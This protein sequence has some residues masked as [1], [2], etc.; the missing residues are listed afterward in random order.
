MLESHRVLSSCYL[1]VKRVISGREAS[2][3]WLGN[4]V[5][6]KA[7]G[8]TRN[9]DSS[10]ARPVS[11]V[12]AQEPSGGEPAADINAEPA[13]SVEDL[14]Q[15]ED[16]FS[17]TPTVANRANPTASPSEIDKQQGHGLAGAGAYRMVRPAVSD[18]IEPPAPPPTAAKRPSGNRVIIG[19][20]RKS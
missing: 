1:P 3:A 7:Q 4:S 18:R 20:A 13:S 6:P 2:R 17:D 16:S 12:S 14:A 15:D 10:V 19:V 11:K 8:T 9:R 5:L